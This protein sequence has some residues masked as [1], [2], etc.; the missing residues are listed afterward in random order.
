MQAIR[1]LIVLLV[2]AFAGC[3]TH[4]KYAVTIVGGPGSAALG[5][6]NEGDTV[7]YLAVGTDQHAFVN[8]GSGPTDIGT[9]GGANSRAWGINDDGLVV[10]EADN[11]G[12]ARRA[13]KFS[14]GTMTDLGTLGGI[15]SLARAVNEDG[16]IVG[17]A[18]LADGS[19]RAFLYT[20]GIM[21]NLGTLPSS[22]EFYSSAGAINKHKKIAGGS[23]AGEFSLPE[24]PAHA[25][26]TRRDGSLEDIGTFGGQFSDA[27][28]INDRGVVV[29]IAATEEL[30][31][32]D[33]FVYF[34]GHKKDIGTLGGGYAQAY[35]INNHD[36]V[37]GTSG[38]GTPERGFIYKK[39]P[40]MV[41]LD[42]RIDP[43]LGWTITDAHAINDKKQIA[44]TGCKAGVCY[45]V[46]LDP[47]R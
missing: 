35:D 11:A 43:A 16:D 41:A 21:T 36:Q 17:S 30:H 10:G 28:G 22:G 13:F 32:D 26:V 4:P 12:G 18:D 8:T 45:A 7:G 47:V 27:W 20:G 42:T 44:G 29:G 5:I 3:A 6:N 33:A 19:P 25:F 46:R 9:L 37:V 38:G 34:K 39:G 40:G 24:P 1:Y 31:F 23:S 15:T 14:G 2:V